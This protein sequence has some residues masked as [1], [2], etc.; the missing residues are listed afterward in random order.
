M[1]NLVLSATLLEIRLLKK[2]L[3][4]SSNWQFLVTGV[5]GV[6]TTYCLLNY[7]KEHQPERIFQLGVAGSFNK[8]IA[9]GTIVAVGNDSFGDLGVWEKDDKLSVFDMGLEKENQRPFKKGSVINLHKNLLKV[10]RLPIVR[11]VSVNTIT[12]SKKEIQYYKEQQFD[13]ETME[14]AAFHYTCLLQ[15]IPFL[16]IRSISNFVGERDKAKW[17]LQDAIENLADYFISSPFINE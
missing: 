7:I 12:T 4:K 14:G 5:G 3:K 2:Y 15:D 17:K 13:I 9:L 1:R 10:C 16:Q 11:A 8:K 6:A